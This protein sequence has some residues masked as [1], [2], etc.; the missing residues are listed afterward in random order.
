MNLRSILRLL[1]H[2]MN[3]VTGTRFHRSALCAVEP[4]RRVE[5]SISGVRNVT[6]LAYPG[7]YAC[8]QAPVIKSLHAT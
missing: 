2:E 1:L 7:G 8:C 4:T 3:L 6:R 5:E